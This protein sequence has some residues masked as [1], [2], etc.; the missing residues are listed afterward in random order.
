MDLK[1]FTIKRNLIFQTYGNFDKYLRSLND[2]DFN[3]FY[4]TALI[5]AKVDLKATFEQ[6]IQDTQA[7]ITALDALPIP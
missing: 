1:E 3:A 5:K 4:K 2:N 6:N 7:K